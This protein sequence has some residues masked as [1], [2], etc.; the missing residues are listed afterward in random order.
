MKKTYFFAII[1]A[2]VLFGLVFFIFKLG[3]TENNWRTSTPE[4]Q[5]MDSGILTDMINSIKENNK[6]VDSIT[7]IRNGYLVEDTYFY[8][9]RKDLRHSFNSV[10]KSFVSA[11]FGIVAQEN[12]IKNTDGK[13]LDYFQDIK[14][15]NIDSFKKEMTLKNLLTMTTG[16][17]WQ[18]ENNVSTNQML[19]SG[20][21]TKFTLD[22]P[23]KEKPGQIFNYCN[24]AAQVLSAVVQK[25]SG[26]AC[27]QLALQKLR[28]LKIRDMYWSSS[29]ENVTS[30]YSGI[31]IYPADAAKFGYLYLKNGVWN[32]KE[33]IP[34][35]WIEESTKAQ[36]KA[37]WGPIFPDYGYMWWINRFGGYAALGYGG[38]YIFVVPKMDLV[39]VF[40]GGLFQGNDLFYPGE[41]ME[42]FILPSIKSN[43]SI[44]NNSD[45]W[46]SLNK[47]SDAVQ[48]APKPELANSLPKIA[49]EIS[50]KTFVMNNSTTF[51]VWFS[52]NKE[53][54]LNQDGHIFKVGLDN[55]FRVTDAKNWYGGLPDHNHR[56]LKGRWLDEKTLE[57]D[58]QD[59]ED[60]FK[61]I[62]TIRFYNDQIELK[63]KSNLSNQEH[64]FSGVIKKEK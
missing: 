7:I 9:Y 18:F 38:Q 11:L 64:I 26:K 56:A 5:G 8:P 39:V 33:I 29:P 22:Q 43:S 21:W 3:L 30:G 62:Y 15:E 40:T 59:L 47:I 24:G 42:K 49:K 31:Y 51:T 37:T 36:I 44:K 45:V 10:T 6:A 53:F 48:K 17:D 54:K 35:K 12:N 27:A 16:L 50:G 25:I 13:V 52:G 32:G 23:M 28:P 14:I 1:I 58:A 2:F 20:N 61:T 46:K 19:N 57:I 63:L 41:L 4:E 60:G 55:I 34:K